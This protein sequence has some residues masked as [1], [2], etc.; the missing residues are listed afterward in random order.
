M[1]PSIPKREKAIRKPSHHIRIPGKIVLQHKTANCKTLYHTNDIRRLRAAYN[2]NRRPGVISA[3]EAGIPYGPVYDDYEEEEDDDDDKEGEY[4]DEEGEYDDGEEDADGDDDDIGGDDNG[5]ED[6]D[7]A[8]NAGDT[9]AA[10]PS[11][12]GNGGGI[13][14]QSSIMIE[15]A[16]V[17]ANDIRR[18]SSAALMSRFSPVFSNRSRDTGESSRAAQYQNQNQNRHQQLNDR[19]EPEIELDKDTSRQ[20]SRIQ[21]V[22]AFPIEDSRQQIGAVNNHR[23]IKKVDDDKSTTVNTH[24]T[25]AN[26]HFT[27]VNNHQSPIM[28]DNDRRQ[29]DK[30]KGIATSHDS[31]ANTNPQASS[32]SSSSGSSNPPPIPRNRPEDGDYQHGRVKNGRFTFWESMT[33][34]QWPDWVVQKALQEEREKEQRRGRGRGLGAVFHSAGVDHVNEERRRAAA[35]AGDSSEILTTYALS[36]IPLSLAEDWHV[37]VQ[38]V[39]VG[40]LRGQIQDFVPLQRVVEK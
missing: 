32:S 27:T 23:Q 35:D 29:N 34:D 22:R 28:D 19:R 7:M 24:S 8:G 26:T 4:D 2:N 37:P 25:A 33:S 39:V 13:L 17:R 12:T 10:G 11:R 15:R 14:K 1:A 9:G 31:C 40:P 5:G 6:K 18:R 38:D 20:P 21:P 36:G 3:R 16:S 30:G